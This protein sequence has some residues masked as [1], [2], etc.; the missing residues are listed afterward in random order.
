MNLVCI[1]AS[2]IAHQKPESSTSY[3]ICQI[4]ARE[5]SKAIS[6]VQSKI[7][8][9]KTKTIHPCVGC[10]KCLDS[11]RCVYSDDFNQIYDD[12]ADADTVFIVSPHYAP[13]PAKLAAMLEKMEQITFLHWGKDSSYKSEV[14]GKPAGVISHG[15]GGEWA[16]KSY[17]KMVNDTITNAL[18]TIQ[19]KV[20]PFSDEWD[21]GLSLPVDKV[22]FQD[23]SIFPLQEYDWDFIADKITLY[24]AAVAKQWTIFLLEACKCPQL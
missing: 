14:Y 15:G 20:V 23:S 17:K 18:D 12:I 8:E 24:V 4:A 9:L 13:I 21:T 3:K 6:G 1:S 16:L 19:M 22:V 10:G 11:H 2:N 5:M 7:I